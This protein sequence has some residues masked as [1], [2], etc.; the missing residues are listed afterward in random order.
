MIVDG[1]NAILGRLASEVAKRLLK[2][3][4][5]EIV[6]CEKIIITGDPVK[7]YEKYKLRR[8]MGSP[9]HGPF[10]PRTPA[11]IVRRTIRGMLPYK[12]PKGRKAFSLLRV[13]V[14]IPKELEDKD[15][16]KIGVKDIES[17]YITVGELAKKLGAKIGE[18]KV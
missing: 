18:K 3:E 16:E 2:G 9:H 12:K 6:N 7:I 17:N 10:F 13:Y 5:V 1:K 15:K 8:D 14:G 11:G 4:K